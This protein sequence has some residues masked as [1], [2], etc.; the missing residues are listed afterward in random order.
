M[1]TYTLNF[2]G[3]MYLE[4]NSEE[5]AYNEMSEMLSNVASDFEIEVYG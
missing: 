2:T 3:V 1:N 5:E 4:A